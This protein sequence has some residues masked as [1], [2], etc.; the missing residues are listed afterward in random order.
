VL[1]EEKINETRARLEQATEITD[2]PGTRDR[3]LEIV[4]SQS[5]KEVNFN[6]FK[7]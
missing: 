5:D 3:H 7:W 1:T 4:S 2:T 6:L